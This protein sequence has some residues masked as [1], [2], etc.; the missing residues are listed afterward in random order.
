MDYAILLIFNIT[1]DEYIYS[2]RLVSGLA[3][4]KILQ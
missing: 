1:I 4:H 3:V 2:F